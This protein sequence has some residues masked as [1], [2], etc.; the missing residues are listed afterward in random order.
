[1]WRWVETLLILAH[2]ACGPLAPLY[3]SVEYQRMQEECAI[4]ARRYF[5]VENQLTEE[6]SRIRE[7]IDILI[8]FAERVNEQQKETPGGKHSNPQDPFLMCTSLTIESRYSSAQCIASHWEESDTIQKTDEER[9]ALIQFKKNEVYITA[10]TTERQLRLNDY[11]LCTHHA[12]Q[13]SQRIYGEFS[14][15]PDANV[16]STQNGGLVL[17]IASD[18][19]QPDCRVLGVHISY[20]GYEESLLPLSRDSFANGFVCGELARA[21]GLYGEQ[22][23]GE[24]CDRRGGKMDPTFRVCKIKLQLEDFWIKQSSPNTIYCHSSE[25][26]NTERTV[27]YIISRGV[28]IAV[29]SRME[30]SYAWAWALVGQEY[31]DRQPRPLGASLLGRLSYPWNDDDRQSGQA[32]M[33]LQLYKVFERLLTFVRAPESSYLHQ[34]SWRDCTFW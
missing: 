28:D 20:L 19:R 32:G 4:S 29:G 18:P 8:Q 5:D 26:R 11:A 15:L 31:R 2:A 22:S 13:K 17:R 12:L 7:S 23:I 16:S 33:R 10:R 1:M 34:V 9:A 14:I 3:K 21:Y 6:I 25:S 24:F 27:V 30:Q